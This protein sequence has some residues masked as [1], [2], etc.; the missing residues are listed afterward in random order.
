MVRNNL[1]LVLVLVIVAAIVGGYAAYPRLSASHVSDFKSRPAD[2]AGKQISLFGAIVGVDEE[3]FAL[4]DGTGTIEV[5]WHGTPPA[6]GTDRVYVQ[7]YFIDG[8]IV[9]S[10]VS[11]WS[12]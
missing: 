4:N 5:K 12:I 8:E 9:A 2:F 11:V 3:G 1:V 7:G 10:S 6:P